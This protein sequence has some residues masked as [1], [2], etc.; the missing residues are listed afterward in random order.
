MRVFLILLIIM[1]FVSLNFLIS[2]LSIADNL[3]TILYLADFVF[4][5]VF[6]YLAFLKAF[7]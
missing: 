5:G 3:K 7:V 1:F 6:V 4:V 2:S